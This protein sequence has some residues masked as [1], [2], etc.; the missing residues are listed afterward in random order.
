MTVKDFIGEKA[1]Y[2]KECFSIFGEDKK[3]G[4]QLLL[5]VRGWGAIS[6]KLKDENKAVQLLDNLGA[7]IAEA[8]NEKLERERK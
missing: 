7:W 6:S 4:L 8:I 1:T 5:D 2:D 3:G